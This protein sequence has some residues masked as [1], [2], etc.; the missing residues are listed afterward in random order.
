MYGS[1][2]P[3][4]N[5]AA[6]DV[7]SKRIPDLGVARWRIG[8]EKRDY[9]QHQTGR[10]E[11]TL[12]G[13]FVHESLLYRMKLTDVAE[14][15]KRPNLLSCHLADAQVAR[16]H[17]FAINDRL[18]SPALFKPTPI[19]RCCQPKVVPQHIEEGGSR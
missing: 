12:R 2:N 18:A 11:A 9:C 15:F 3:V 16:R 6:A 17:G 7:N 13:L 19:S 14:P 10:T 1:Q 8:F 4:V 5:P